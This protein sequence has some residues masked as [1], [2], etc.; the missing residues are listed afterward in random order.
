MNSR[1]RGVAIIQQWAAIAALLFLCS[2]NAQ[3]IEWPGYT[4]VES[5][6]G[7]SFLVPEKSVQ[8][9]KRPILVLLPFTG[10][11]AFDLLDRWYTESLSQ[12]ARLR[13]MIV[14]LPSAVGSM[15]DYATGAAWSATMKRYTEG[16]A[17]DV[18][19]AIRSHDGDP[20]RVA[21]AGY[22]MGGDLAWALIQRDRERYSGAVIMG[23]RATYREKGALERLSQR[24][25]RM[26]YFMGESE[27]EARVSGANAAKDAA[28]R[29][30]ISLRVASAPGAHVTAPPVIFADAVDYVLGF[31]GGRPAFVAKAARPGIS[32]PR[33]SED[34]AEE[35]EDE[36]SY[37]P[38]RRVERRNAAGA[39]NL[40]P[41]RHP[42]RAAT[43][44]ERPEE[45]PTCD[46]K[47]FED[48]K[49]Y[50]GWAY[51]NAKGRFV[52]DFQ[53]EDAE[54]FGDDG[55]AMIWDGGPG[56]LNCKGEVFKVLNEFGADEF[57]DD[58]VRF[59]DYTIDRTGNH[60]DT[61]GFL[62][63]RGQVVLP[64]NYDYATSFCDGVARVGSDCQIEKN[65]SALEINV[66]CASWW[67][68]DLQGRV[69]RNPKF[70]SDCEDILAKPRFS[71]PE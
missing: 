27:S 7:S 70:D 11:A 51:K 43:T 25:F 65:G 45:L 57:S 58:L 49:N 9:G 69:A 61:I 2:A 32:P 33:V 39:R 56:Y 17:A 28:R 60:H 37:E 22:S 63:R 64:A 41:F 62:N 13:G 19:E 44:T 20:A 67:F 35:E 21:L 10:G 52:V 71:E 34:E 48:D 31:E 42:L 5:A 47:P 12:H 16:V 24:R 4:T 18:A 6:D 38:Q 55:L 3:A 14:V 46:W 8:A 23:S 30:G 15:D 26:F 53:F 54:E 50:R 29:A 36:S 68:I 40:G 59:E 1:S 66:E